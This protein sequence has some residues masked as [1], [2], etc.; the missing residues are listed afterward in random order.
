MHCTPVKP[1]H[2]RSSKGSASARGASMHT[3][4]WAHPTGSNHALEADYCTHRFL[5]VRLCMPTQ[6]TQVQPTQHTQVH[7]NP[8]HTGSWH[9]PVHANPV[10]A[11]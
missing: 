5:A 10:M 4:C 11:S 1:E 9:A 7:A 2:R 6:H 3:T 8:A